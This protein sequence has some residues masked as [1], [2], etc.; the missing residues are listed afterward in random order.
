MHTK[1][2]TYRSAVPVIFKADLRLPGQTLKHTSST[3]RGITYHYFLTTKNMTLLKVPRHRLINRGRNQGYSSMHRGRILAYVTPCTP[4]KYILWESKC[5][6]S[7]W[8]IY[9]CT[10]FWNMQPIYWG[11]IV[12]KTFIKFYEFTKVCHSLQCFIKLNT[13][14]HTFNVCSIPLQINN[15]VQIYALGD[16]AW[17]WDKYSLSVHEHSKF[18]HFYHFKSIKTKQN[19]AHLQCVV[20]LCMNLTSFSIR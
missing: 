2:V 18:Y 3:Y 4:S 1:G 7:I 20:Y 10:R 9:T 17:T 15:N 8:H 19:S 5:F 6:T 13:T 14:L 11:Q 12:T 16:T